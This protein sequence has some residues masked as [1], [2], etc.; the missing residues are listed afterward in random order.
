MNEI[1]RLYSH[2]LKHQKI[3]TDSRKE[4]EGAIF[5]A[6]SGETFNGN[7]F[8]K[9]ALDK[10]A[11]LAVV[12]DRDI[13]DEQ[14]ARFF[15]VPDVLKALQDLAHWHRQ[16]FQIPLLGITGT[17]GKTTTKELVH[18][19]LKTEKEIIFTQGNLNNHIGVPVTLLSLKPTTEIAVVEMGA[20]HP[21]EIEALCRIANPTHGIITNIGKAHLEGFGSY[22]GVIKTKNELYESIRKS[23]GVVFVNQNDSLLMKLSEGIK[24]ITY[25]ESNAE[26]TGELVDSKP[27]LRI[28]STLEI[29]PLDIETKLYG[30]YNFNNAMAAIAVG[31]YFGITRENIKQALED[32]EPKNNRSQVVKT[33]RNTIIL[34][35]YNANPGSMPL[36]IETFSEQSY[37]DKI[38]ILGDMFELGKDSE[39][40]HQRIIELLK[41]KDFKQIILVGKDFFNS[42]KD[43]YF[44]AFK[45]TE[46]AAAY[47]NEQKFTGNTIL[48]KGSRGMKLEALVQYL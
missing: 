25:G 48:I 43:E 36:A 47:L 31:K 28:K 12:D 18:S 44:T 11:A 13:L 15:Y 3:C 6:L 7:R 16:Q 30:N 40:E 33:K 42:Q 32:Y 19:V 46:K 27:F 21:G 39:K 9:A 14:E 23:G 34:D 1:E 5:F 4:V 22:E 26:I 41:D 45:T 29:G 20:N 2:F 24:R 8:A 38:I 35:A 10:G 37:N 17:N